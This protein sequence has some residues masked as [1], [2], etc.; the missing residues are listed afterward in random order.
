[1]RG[2][3]IVFGIHTG[4]WSLLKHFERALA[5][6]LPGDVLAV[7]HFASEGIRLEGLY[8]SRKNRTLRRLR[9][10]SD[11]RKKAHSRYTKH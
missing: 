11:D 2:E 3:I 7:H 5:R 1:M 4:R 9:E 8:A 10:Q 6:T